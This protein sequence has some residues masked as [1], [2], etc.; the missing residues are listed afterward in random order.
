MHGQ[1]NAYSRCRRQ[2]QGTDYVIYVAVRPQITHTL[3]L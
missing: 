2:L 1:Q 3:Y